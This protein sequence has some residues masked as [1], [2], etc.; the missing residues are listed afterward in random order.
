MRSDQ[1]GQ[2]QG[3]SHGDWLG[4]WTLAAPLPSSL[5]LVSVVFPGDFWDPGLV[6]RA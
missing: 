6:L 2:K 5:S 4:R 1:S 3:M